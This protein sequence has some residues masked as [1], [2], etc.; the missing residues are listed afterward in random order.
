MAAAAEPMV[1]THDGGLRFVTDIRGHRLVVD[2]P[3]PKG[4]DTAPMPVELLGAAL[5]TCIALYVQQ[6]CASRAL[7]Y[8]G[9]RVELQ[10]HSVKHPYRL[11]SF[12]VRI[13]LPEPLAPEHLEMLERVARSCPVHN[14]LLHAPR[15]DI[16][17]E[18]GAAAAAA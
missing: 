12:A 18:T 2:Q 10:Q 14:T 7:P 5:G 6:Y 8:E 13:V 9:M 1:V 11:G 17:I 15:L 4:E 3:G 16:A